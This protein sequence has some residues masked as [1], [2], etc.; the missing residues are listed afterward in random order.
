MDIYFVSYHDNI[1]LMTIM[2]NKKGRAG[3]CSHVVRKSDCFLGKINKRPY[4]DVIPEQETC[5]LFEL[6]YCWN[7]KI[8]VTTLYHFFP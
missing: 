3:H 4:T 1:K 7:V 8:W 6:R 5:V 2:D